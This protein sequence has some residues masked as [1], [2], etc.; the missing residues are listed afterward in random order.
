MP[1]AQQV[2]GSQGGLGGGGGGGGLGGGGP[3][4]VTTAI[5]RAIKAIAEADGVAASLPDATKT[6]LLRSLRIAPQAFHGATV[7]LSPTEAFHYAGFYDKI[8]VV[9]PSAAPTPLERAGGT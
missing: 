6:I 8:R 7:F 3:A 9:F 2:L 4:D 5:A 1:S